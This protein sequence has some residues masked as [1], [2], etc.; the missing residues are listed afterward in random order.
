VL[1]DNWLP[2]VARR[3]QQRFDNIGAMHNFELGNEFEVALCKV[4][5][6][7]LPRRFGVCRGFVVG[8]NGERAGDDIIVFDAQR[9]PTIRALATDFS[10]KESVPA[11]AVLAYIEA[12]HTLTVEGDEN[13]PQSLAKATTQIERV[14]KV[15]RP[16]VGHGE[17]I[18]GVDLEGLFTATPAP[19]LP[20]IRN[21]YYAAVWARRVKTKSEDA[22]AAFSHRL[23]EVGSERS[24]LPDAI[25]AGNALALPVVRSSEEKGSIKPFVCESTELASM[26]NEATPWG[27]AFAHMLWAMEWIRLGELPWS[28]MLTEQ[29]RIKNLAFANPPLRGS[30]FDGSR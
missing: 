7:L 6:D 9:F 4:L 28:K 23:L 25:V 8:R 26:L 15:P 22:F 30:K 29:L 20:T 21:P 10:Q 16:P 19:G 27:I 14:K 3:F 11:E 24:E 18:S 1:Y 2:D 13:A 17:L 5:V 12:K